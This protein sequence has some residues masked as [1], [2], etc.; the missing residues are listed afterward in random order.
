MSPLTFG[1]LIPMTT[2]C[3]LALAT[4]MLTRSPNVGMAAALTSWAVVVLAGKA[5]TE[6]W[7]TA[8]T[9]VSLVPFY[10]LSAVILIG[11]TFHTS[12]GKREEG[13]LWG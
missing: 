2:V 4:A 9:E 11:V 6:K 7:T 8:V 3:A 12:R 1:W 5:V 10:V 13:M